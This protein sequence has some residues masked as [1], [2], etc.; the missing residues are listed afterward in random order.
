MSRAQIGFRVSIPAVL[1]AGA[2]VALYSF[3]TVGAEAPTITTAQVTRGEIVQTIAASG[4]LEAVTTVQVGTQVSGTVK[5][6]AADFN[7]LVRKGQLLA[8]LDPSLLQAQVDQADAS[9]VKAQAD[10]DRS[11]VALES[12]RATLARTSAL[13]ARKLIPATDLDAASI[14]VRTAE[15]QV[16]SAD[17]QVTQALAS[18][19]QARVNLDHTVITAP[20]DGIV[21]SRNVDAG[22]TVAASMS[23]PT[24]FVLAAD[25]TR[26]RVVAKLDESDIAH[27]KEGQPVTFRVD[28]YPGETFEGS[29]AQV[30]LQGEVVS[31]VVTYVTVIDVA[32]DQLKLK[33]GM[34]ANVTV[35]V[36]RSA[37]AMRLP[38]AALRLRPTAGQLAAYGV[39]AA[40]SAPSP[41]GQG[42]KIATVW[43]WVGGTLERVGITTGMTDGLVTEVVGGPLSAGDQ[44]VTSLSTAASASA[45][46]AKATAG[47]QATVKNPLMGSGMPGP[48]PVR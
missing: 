9:L 31:N 21:I 1:L 10:A 44:V 6:L 41:P 43:R 5:D 38:N 3:M 29:V 42:A 4:T 8:R 48:P 40:T 27:V 22:Q 46:A 16:K 11:R 14:D 12:A 13:S 34:T 25:L 30:R 18:R 24:L 45:M 7:D 20:I 28:A 39:K 2:A 26:M 17:A 47:A 36:A 32:N 19:N 23:A 33:P 35:Q 37:A 15:A